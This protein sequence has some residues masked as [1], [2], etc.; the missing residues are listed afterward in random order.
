MHFIEPINQFVCDECNKE[1]ISKS[2][3]INHRSCHTGEKLSCADCNKKFRSKGS[4]NRHHNALHSGE[5][6]KP[7][8][9]PE[10]DKRY[11]EKLHTDR[12]L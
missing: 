12:T 5:R 2:G 10:C 8:A 6:P 7:Y 9:C 4:L 3:L 11:Y 1:F